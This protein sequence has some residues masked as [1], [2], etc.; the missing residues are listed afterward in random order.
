MYLLGNLSIHELG[1]KKQKLAF[2][3]FCRSSSIVTRS[4][5]FCFSILFGSEMESCYTLWT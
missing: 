4:F 1:D 2:L 3:F 5:V